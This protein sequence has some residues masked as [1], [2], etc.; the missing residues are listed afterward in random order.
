MSVIEPIKPNSHHKNG[1]R[2]LI[3][4]FS[5]GELLWFIQQNGEFWA[6]WRYRDDYL[7]SRCKKLLVRGLVRRKRCEPGMDIF[8]PTRKSFSSLQTTVRQ[9]SNPSS[10]PSPDCDE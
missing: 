3:R 9:D 8:V 10:I 1:R 6:S 7:R 2:K 4:E 5:L